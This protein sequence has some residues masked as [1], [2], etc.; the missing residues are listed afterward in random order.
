MDAAREMAWASDPP[1]TFQAARKVSASN[2]IQPRNA[3]ARMG[4]SARLMVQVSS[5]PTTRGPRMLAKV[6]TQITPAVANTL[7][8]GWAIEGKNSARYPTAATAIAMLPIQL[9]N[10]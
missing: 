2:Q 4:I 5:A 9:P 3:T 1:L 10:Q 6:S 8:G 7:A